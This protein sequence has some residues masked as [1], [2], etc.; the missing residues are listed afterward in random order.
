M[1]GLFWGCDFKLPPKPPDVFFKFNSVPVGLG[2]SYVVSADLN[3]DGEADLVSANSRNHSLSILFG[4]GN[5]SF[6]STTLRVPLEP[7]ALVVTD[8]NKDGW[9]DIVANSRGTNSLTVLLGKGKNSFLKP[10]SIPTGQVPLSITLGDFNEDGFSDAAVT[11][12]FSKMEIYLGKGDGR[13]IKGETY[14]TGSRSFSGVTGDFNGDSHLDIALAVHS[15]NASSIRLYFGKGDGTFHTSKKIAQG[16]GCLALAQGDMNADGFTDLVAASGS[17]DNLFFLAA[18]G[19]GTFK[20]E[21]AFSGG[22]GPIALALDD[23]D[24]DKL[25]DV[26][27]A[28]S[29]SSSFSLITRNSNGSF[30]FPVRD[31]VT[32]GT[33]L[34]LT[35]GDFNSDGLSDIAV[36]S[37]SEG[38]VDIFL[39]KAGLQVAKREKISILAGA[40]LRNGAQ[41]SPLVEIIFDIPSFDRINFHKPSPNRPVDAQRLRFF[42]RA[43]R[44]AFRTYRKVYRVGRGLSVD[45]APESI[46]SVSPCRTPDEWS[47]SGG[48]PPGFYNRQNSIGWVRP[49][50]N[51]RADTGQDPSPYPSSEPGHRT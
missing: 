34:M 24:D 27:V 28:N 46:E 51:A 36:A 35:T 1:C 15:S 42:Y 3:L 11:L 47:R 20:K 40:E 5:G 4:R 25:I 38:T 30:H 26:A 32:G 23:F 39:E 6:K 16:L 33:P 8:V 14:E 31:Y 19:D 13:F 29:R 9:P 17:G 45:E 22:G 41:L 7:S 43:R 44:V 21:I 10:R 37:N 48:Q 50:W 12:T 18:N 49:G 2:P